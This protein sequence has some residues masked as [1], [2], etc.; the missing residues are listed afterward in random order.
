[1]RG[2]TQAFA[3]ELAAAPLHFRFTLPAGKPPVRVH[4]MQVIVNYQMKLNVHLN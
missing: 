2:S 1:M 3:G 4:G